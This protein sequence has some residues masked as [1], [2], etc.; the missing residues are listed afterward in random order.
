[1]RRVEDELQ[2]KPEHR[3]HKQHWRRRVELEYELGARNVIYVLVD[4]KS[5]LAYI[6]EAGDLVKRLL[7]PHNSIPNWEFFRYDVLPEALTP[8]RVALERMLIRDIASVLPNN[9]EI[10]WHDI[11][12]YTLVN[13]RID[14]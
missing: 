9:R 7:Q 2:K 12:G 5:K 11:S 10:P 4:S 13:D 6:G 1:M 14:G 8:F 3:I